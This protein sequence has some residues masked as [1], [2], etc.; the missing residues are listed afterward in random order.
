MEAGFVDVSVYVRLSDKSAS[1]AVT[2]ISVVPTAVSSP[3]DNVVGSDANC[4]V[5]PKRNQITVGKKT[6]EIFN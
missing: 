1:V 3:A 2:V 5:L 6:V 4:G